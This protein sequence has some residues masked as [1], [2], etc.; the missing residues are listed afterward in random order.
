MAFRKRNYRKPVRRVK[1]RTRVGRKTRGV[2]QAVKKYVNRTIHKQIEN[3]TISDKND[4]DFASYLANIDLS[5]KPLM[6]STS[7]M[8]IFQGTG[9]G[10][11]VGNTITTRKLLFKYIIHPN[12]QDPNVN[13]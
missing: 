1:P 13:P 2:T 8:S 9:Q 6:P 3:K 5:V 4:V 10:Q 11:R 7:F 12:P